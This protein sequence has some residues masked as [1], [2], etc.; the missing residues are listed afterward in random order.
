[1]ITEKCVHDKSCINHL[2]QYRHQSVDKKYTKD[3]TN[4]DEIE[5][6]DFEEL[7]GHMNINE[8]NKFHIF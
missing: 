6:D 1:M 8:R 5:V 2:C 3:T 7:N 4:A